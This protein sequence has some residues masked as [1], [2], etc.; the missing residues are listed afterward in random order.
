[1]LVE[2]GKNVPNAL[3]EAFRSWNRLGTVGI[4]DEFNLEDISKSLVAEVVKLP[5]LIG[6]PS[7]GMPLHSSTA[8]VALSERTKTTFAIP[9]LAPPGPYESSTRLTGPTVSA[10]YSY[11]S[12]GLVSDLDIVHIMESRES[13]RRSSVR[14]ER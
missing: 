9:R 11:L 1:M 14:K 5:T 2:N 12:Q 8:L 6:R 13:R 7:T 10:K 3:A 4:E